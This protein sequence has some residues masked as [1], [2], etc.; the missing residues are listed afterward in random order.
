MLIHRVL[1]LLPPGDEARSPALIATN[2]SL[3]LPTAKSG[4]KFICS[5]G[6]QGLAIIAAAHER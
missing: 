3:G 4:V 2:I 1:L 6:G 5:R